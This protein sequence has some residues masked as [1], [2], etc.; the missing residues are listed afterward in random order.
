VTSSPSLYLF[1]AAIAGAYLGLL[2][3]V[4]SSSWLVASGM[5]AALTVLAPWRSTRAILLLAFC[6][7]C[8][9][10][11]AQRELSQF[12]SMTNR[13]PTQ[14]AIYEGTVSD[15]TLSLDKSKRGKIE[16]HGAIVDE[17]RMGLNATLWLSIKQGAAAV[18]LKSGDIIRV[19]GKIKKLQ[20][21]L[22]PG[23]FNPYW[24]GFAR[25]IQGTLALHDPFDLVIV[26]KQAH[27]ALFASL[28]DDLRSRLVALTTPREAGVLL[29]LII[30]DTA[31]FDDAHKQIYRQVGAGHLLAVSGLQVSLLAF[32]FFR[33]FHLL[34]LFMP[35]VGRLSKARPI[36]ALCAMFA[37]WSFVML[38]G[39]PPSA[40]RAAAMSSVLLVGVL[41]RRQVT[42]LD[43][44]GIA[45]LFTLLLAPSAVVDPSFLLSY[46]AVFGLIVSSAPK[47]EPDALEEP[48]F[49]RRQSEK[50]YALV[51]ASISAGLMT[52]CISA[53]LFGELAWG[54][55]IANIVLVPIAVFLQTPAIFLGVIGA[56]LSSPFLVN[57]GSACA[58]FI[59]ALCETLGACLGHLQLITAP[60][61]VAVSLC[62]VATL[63]FVRTLLSPKKLTGFACCAVLI[64]PI[65]FLQIDT[66]QGLRITV[67]PV[68]QG[69]AAVF[70][71]PNRQ[72]MIVDGGGTHDRAY[73]PGKNVVLPFLQR[74]GIDHID[75][76]VLSHPDGDH[77]IGLFSVLEALSI[78]EIWH[79]GYD[80]S[81]PLMAE[82][83]GLAK[84]KNIKLRTPSE[85][86][87]VHDLGGVKL[88]ILAPH[89]A[90]GGLYPDFK[91]NDNSLVLKVSLGSDSALW[92]GDIERP[93][94]ERLLA[95][96]PNLGVSVV[97]A[98]HH[99]SKT[100]SSPQLVASTSPQHVIFC[101][102][103]GNMWGFPHSQI[104]KRWQDQGAT[105]WNTGTHGEITIWLTGH[106]VN[107][108]PF[109][110]DAGG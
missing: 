71:L 76:V 32:L 107:V 46:A 21:A 7:L 19:K 2:T 8:V 85:L 65:A 37:I 17:K 29:A 33:F 38:C 79:S 1:A 106:G 45:G 109:N 90:Q 94:E 50:A 73:D 36:A 86:M 87:G 5:V 99:G 81:H 26:Q 62:M 35:R 54:G 84:R 40:V 44:F 58:G 91:T 61:G 97:K 104:A 103:E 64:A 66:Q 39:A 30:G 83:L 110:V 42:M 70:E 80:D 52:L 24:F 47:R 74:R 9:A 25:K 75:V 20:N 43:A 78:G 56:S 101:T 102:R 82:L 77:I 11:L 23:E 53:N 69:D 72:V 12:T 48:S 10:G 100:S 15:L 49:W 60:S 108:K 98:P 57:I 105:T 55:L 68:G 63:V 41:L 28:R 92:L 22:S 51:V 34:L 27:P 89:F 14:E 31:L 96:Y 93:G 6:I 59:E 67:L 88:E 18:D 16:V 95:Q 3:S 13:L 4:T